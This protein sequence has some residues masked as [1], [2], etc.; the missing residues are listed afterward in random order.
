MGNK[1]PEKLTGIVQ[2]DET[3]C[4]GKL[5]LMNNRRRL[6]LLHADNT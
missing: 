2:A 4:G 1:K 3:Y 6:K 5:P